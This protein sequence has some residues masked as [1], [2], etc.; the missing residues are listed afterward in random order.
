VERTTLEH[1]KLSGSNNIKRFN[2][3]A[4]AE[5]DAPARIDRSEEIAQLDILI[6]KTLK[7]CSKGSVRNKKANPAFNHLVQLANLREMLLRGHD[8][9]VEASND[10]LAE[11]DAALEGNK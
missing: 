11:I 9:K 8:P 3:R 5:A 4:K 10:I 7:A 2:D 1:L 6:A